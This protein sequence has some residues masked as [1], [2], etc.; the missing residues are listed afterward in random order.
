[1]KRILMKEYGFVRWPEEDFSDD[2]NRFYCFKVGERV[3]VSKLV[4]QGTVFI[5]ARIDDIRLPFEIYSKLPHYRAL[6]KLNGVS[7]ESL[8]SSDLKQLYEDC[9]EYEK[10]YTE[11]EQTSAFPTLTTIVK[12]CTAVQTKSRL[13]L[14]EIERLVNQNFTKVVKNLSTHGWALFGSHLKSIIATIE[15]YDPNTYPQT[16]L[17]KS[18]SFNF[19]KPDCSELK[20]DWR[21]EEVIRLINKAIAE[22]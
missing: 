14:N 15:K 9:L 13:E 10:E 21:Y 3:R 11:A 20:P 2:G 22:D 7:L 12:Q 17:G 16:I 5:S 4:S 1:M 19:C 6:D 18:K 8:Q